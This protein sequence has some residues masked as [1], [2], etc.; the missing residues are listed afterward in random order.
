MLGQQVLTFQKFNSNEKKENEMLGKNIKN[1]IKLIFE[2]GSN[3]NYIFFI[4]FLTYD[5]QLRFDSFKNFI[6]HRYKG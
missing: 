3:K 2:N 6:R 5:L 4:G 1:K